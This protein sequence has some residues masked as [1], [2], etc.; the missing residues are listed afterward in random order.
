MYIHIFIEGLQSPTIKYLRTSLALTV[1]S[2]DL[3]SQPLLVNFR[4][5]VNKTMNE[6]FNQQQL[7]VQLL[8]HQSHGDIIYLKAIISCINRKRYQLRAQIGAYLAKKYCHCTFSVGFV[9]IFKFTSSTLFFWWEKRNWMDPRRG[10]PCSFILTG[11]LVFVA[12]ES[13]FLF[14]KVT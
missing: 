2:K 11:F 7:P 13:L 9:I 12:A 5:M 6:Y 8:T 10:S 3:R 14:W 1:W 4:L